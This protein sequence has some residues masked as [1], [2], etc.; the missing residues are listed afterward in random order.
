MK[1]GEKPTLELSWWK[2]GKPITL[3][4]TDLNEALAKYENAVQAVIKSKTGK[5]YSEAFDSI[6]GVGRAAKLVIQACNPQIHAETISCLQLYP[7]LLK[8]KKEEYQKKYKAGVSRASGLIDD[9]KDKIDKME[10]RLGDAAHE[11]TMRMQS[12]EQTKKFAIEGMAALYLA[13][14]ELKER[15]TV[16]NIGEA[17]KNLTIKKFVDQ[18]SESKKKLDEFGVDVQKAAKGVV[19]I[20]PVVKDLKG[21]L[22]GLLSDEVINDLDDAK[23]IITRLDRYLNTT[24]DTIH[25]ARESLVKLPDTSILDLN[26]KTK[27][28]VLNEKV[29]IDFLKELEEYAALQQKGIPQERQLRKG[30]ELSHQLEALEKML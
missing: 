26:D 8:F 13:I 7:S 16:K 24:L 1:K 15:G 10:D 9:V 3:K 18:I 5:N 30:G 22:A 21:K 23:K 4:N 20:L 29:S 6:E 25:F 12:F 19:D 11:W 28:A 17:K 2:K 27:L 14:Q